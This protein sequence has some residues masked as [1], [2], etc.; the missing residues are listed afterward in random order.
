M[1]AIP[2]RKRRIG[3]VGSVLVMLPVIVVAEHVHVGSVKLKLFTPA[4][5]VTV[6][7][8][9]IGVPQT[10]L[11]DVLTENGTVFAALP[12]A[13]ISGY[14]EL[15]WVMVTPVV[16]LVRIPDTPVADEHPTLLTATLRLLH[17]FKSMTP[18][19]LPPEMV[20][21]PRLRTA[22]PL[23]HVL[24]VAVPPSVMTTVAE[25]LGAQLSAGSLAITV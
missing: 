8:K 5:E 19:P 22:A 25:L 24:N 9:V 1:L 3:I 20:R 17:S 18:F 23:R 21:V 14:G 15:P 16:L 11:G 4:L 6:S 10:K 7:V 2:S 13:G 12:P